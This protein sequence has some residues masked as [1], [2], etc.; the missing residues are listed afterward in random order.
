MHEGVSR[1][2]DALDAFAINGFPEKRARRS[3]EE[4]PCVEKQLPRARKTGIVRE[5]FPG[6][7]RGDV[8][9]GQVLRRVGEAFGKGVNGI[10]GVGVHGGWC[11]FSKA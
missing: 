2:V 7:E 9:K 4:M 6:Q 5:A 8:R 11:L 10:L 1:S 3:F